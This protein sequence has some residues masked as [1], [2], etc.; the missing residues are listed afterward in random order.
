MQI[1]TLWLMENQ[2]VSRNVV[3]GEDLRFQKNHPGRS[4]SRWKERKLD[5]KQAKQERRV[6]TE[7]VGEGT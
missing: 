5:E 6:I 1:L 2:K 7:Q 4:K 3:T